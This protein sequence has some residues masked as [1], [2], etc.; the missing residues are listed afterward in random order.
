MG[1]LVNGKWS[2][3][4]VASAAQ[5]EK[6][7]F[8]RAE[9]VCRDWVTADGSSPFPAQAKRYHLLLAHNC[10][11]ARPAEPPDRSFGSALHR[12][13]TTGNQPSGNRPAGNEPS[14]DQRGAG[15]PISNGAEIG[16]ADLGE[17]IEYPKGG[18]FV[19]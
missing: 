16:V 19:T 11:W 9:S 18:P 12:A 7:E 2:E 4:D 5:N 6:G 15:A 10:P 14:G 8:R 17:P 3:D 1:L 13:L